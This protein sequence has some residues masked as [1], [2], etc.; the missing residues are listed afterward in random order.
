V[1]VDDGLATGSTA[2][3]A[4]RALR[5]RKPDRLVLAVPVSA[6]DTARAL[7]ED[8]D[9][10]ITLELPGEFGAVGQWYTDFRQTE[11]AE[12]ISLLEEFRETGGLVRNDVWIPIANG[13]LPGVMA[14]PAG[15]RGMV[16]F[17]H[18]TGSSRHSPRNQAVAD[19]LNNH[20]FGTLLF[21][22]LTEGEAQNRANVFDIDLLASRLSSAIDWLMSS[23]TLP[24][25]PVGLFGASTG[26]AAAL[27]ASIGRPVAAVVSRG[28]RPDLARPRLPDV[29]A[30]VLLI[31]GSRD[32]VVLDLNQAAAEELPGICELSVVPGAG[33]LFEESGALADVAGH[34]IDWFARWLVPEGRP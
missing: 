20:G 27:L 8:A 2:R 19:A 4:L 15:M 14:T 33:H 18:G 5:A 32:P 30:P 21:D 3:A 23:S 34:A 1:V 12:V 13:R 10:V 28:G 6:R 31:V 29:T 16:V 11:D 26:A 17:A 25:L 7:L 22:L 24:S 9:D